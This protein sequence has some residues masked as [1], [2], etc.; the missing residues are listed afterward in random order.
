MVSL[1]MLLL[2]VLV[3]ACSTAKVWENPN[4]P[5]EQWSLDRAACQDQARMQAEREFTLDQQ[6]NRSLPQNQA[7]PWTSQMD[8]FSAQQRQTQL[9]GTCMSSRG[10][11]L[12]PASE[13][14]EPPAASGQP[15]ADTAGGSPK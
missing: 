11:T 4:V 15:P 14:S 6:A 2:P 1:R 12:V 8:R 5:R 3:A 13:A 10:Y 7:A 9:F